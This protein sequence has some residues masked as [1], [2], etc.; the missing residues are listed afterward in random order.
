MKNSPSRSVLPWKKK[1]RILLLLLTLLISLGLGSQLFGHSTD[2]QWSRTSPEIN[3]GHIF[4][5]AIN[6]RG[7][8]T[9]F[10]AR[11]GGHD[12]RH[13]RLKAIKSGPNRSGV[14][15]AKVEI[16]DPRTGRWKEKFSTFYPDT[17]DRDQV[18]K[19]ILHAWN[20]RNRNRGSKWQGPSG[21]GF[22]IQ[23]YLNR[24]GNINTAYPLYRAD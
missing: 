23:G 19:V 24:R 13:A 15:T 8:P 14:Y 21:K 1:P 17:M 9:G 5:G 11:P 10:H 4:E 20:H 16:F 22:T 2:R 7:K 18:I 3:L 12:P 6:S